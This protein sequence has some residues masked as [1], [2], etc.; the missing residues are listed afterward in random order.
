VD[1]QTLGKLLAIVGVSLAIVG[2]AF[3]LGGRMGLGSLPGSFRF[4]GQ[5]WSCFVPIT[6][7]ILI[8]LLLTLVLNLLLRL[9]SR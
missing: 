4:E 5:G 9:F 8:S 3:W 2:A 7:S 6:A 1:L